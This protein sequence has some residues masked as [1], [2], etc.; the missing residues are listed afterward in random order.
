MNI[1]YLDEDIDKIVDYHCDKHVVKMT[2]ESI[3]MLATAYYIQH[4]YG[5][6]FKKLT[7]EEISFMKNEVF[8]DFPREEI[9]RTSHPYHPSTQW[10]A[11]SINNWNWLLQ[12]GMKLSAE[13]TK[14]YGKEHATNP[15][16]EWMKNNPP[17]NLPDIPWT[18]PPLAMPDIY[19]LENVVE[20]YRN[21]YIHD[22]P[23]ATWDR[24]NNKPEWFEKGD[25]R[26]CTG[27]AEEHQV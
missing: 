22:K 21:F 3:Q 13:F 2:V 15:R 4:G 10:A 1:F 20:S 7:E 23:F 12:L 26:I 19:K 9:Y 25:F 8:V 17:T 6:M 14:R 5:K 18:P 16:F 27:S 24:L 11:Q